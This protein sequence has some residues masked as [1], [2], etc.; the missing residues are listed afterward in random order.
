MRRWISLALLT[1]AC[2]SPGT[3][4]AWEQHVGPTPNVCLPTLGGAQL[5]ADVAW[6]DGWRVQRHVWTGHHRLLDPE[7]QRRAWGSRA[8]C[9][10]DL[11]RHAAPEPD[12]AH[13]VVLLHG[14]GRT[15]RSLAGLE[16]ELEGAGWR[17]ARLTYP[18]TRG[19]ITEHAQDV[20]SVLEQLEG[21]SRVSLVTH[22]LG[23]VVAR[24]L[25]GDPDAEWRLH[26]DTGALVQL[27]PPN[28]GAELAERVRSVLPVHRL[29]WDPLQPLRPGV[30]CDL[31]VPRPPVEVGIITGGTGDQRGYS[32]LLMGD[33]DGKVG[34]AEAMIEGMRDFKV[35]PVRHPWVMAT[36]SV[37]DH[38]V[39]FLDD[40]HF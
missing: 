3:L 35:L 7:D 33:N 10:E 16:Q 11:R 27:A 8:R 13:L 6:R 28:Q 14:L 9:I 19:S 40:G 36:P 32:P 1:A 5:W 26:V 20:A 38:V 24:Q 31:P 39:S 37:L 18:S 15:R 4:A 17:V 34:V 25:L 30:P 29:G 23:G 22:S 12:G 2:H 21:V